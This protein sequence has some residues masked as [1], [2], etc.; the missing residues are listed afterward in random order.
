M[1][2][3]GSI[4]LGQLRGKLQ[5]LEIACS[6]CDRAGRLRLDRLVAGH[7]A[8]IVLP[9]LRT[10]LAGD[11]LRAGSV[12]VND[13]CGVHFPQLR[14]LFPMTCRGGDDPRFG[15]AAALAH[16]AGYGPA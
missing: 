3:S 6:R 10:I 1:S 8:D 15:G 16:T 7:G 14:R 11:C 5:L 13:R 4:A 12:S 2:P 9:E